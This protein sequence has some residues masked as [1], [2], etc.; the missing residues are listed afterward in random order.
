MRAGSGRAERPSWQL[1]WG[2]PLILAAAVLGV[3]YLVTPV[4]RAIAL[5]GDGTTY[6]Q[7][8]TD[9]WGK[10]G[11]MHRFRILVPAVVGWLPM[12]IESGFRLVQYVSCFLASLF[13]CR[14]ARTIG[15]ELRHATLAA[16][17]FLLTWPTIWNLYQYRLVDAAACAFATAGL[18]LILRGELTA[19]ILVAG[20]G[21]LAKEA[22]I[23]IIPLAAYLA[24]RTQNWRQRLRLGAVILLALAP[25]AVV[26]AMVSEAGVLSLHGGPGAG[27]DGTLAYIRIWF[28]IQMREVGWWRS[29][30]FIFLPFTTLWLLAPLG[31]ARIKRSPRHVLV[32]WLVL[33]SPLI[34]LGSPERMIE[35][36]A[37]ALIPLAVSGLTGVS[38]VLAVLIVLGN[39]LFLMRVASAVVP[40]WLAWGSLALALV[41]AGW[42]WLR[43]LQT[44]VSSFAAWRE[45]LSS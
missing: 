18:L 37:P 45:S 23:L 9:L 34:L 2:V 14:I 42:V 16:L 4:N 6:T 1:E 19:A 13:T 43:A 20:I 22:V 35:I 24:S 39:S 17:M 32:A 30:L 44:D 36:Q 33:T 38:P 40:F 15:L 12:D 25:Y 8:V 41:G 3:L 10:R 27:L 31:V 5:L 28:H 26:R 21:T 7:M 11:H 29:L